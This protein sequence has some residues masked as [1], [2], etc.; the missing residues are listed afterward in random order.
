MTGQRPPLGTKKSRRCLRGS[1][2]GS[3]QYARSLYTCCCGRLASRKK[4]FTAARS[5]NSAQP[6]C[7]RTAK[8]TKK[9][10][11]C[12][13]MYKRTSDL[14]RRLLGKGNFSLFKYLEQSFYHWPACSGNWI[15][16]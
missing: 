12:F 5:A 1:A 6:P 8:R 7:G 10:L 9:T 2:R 13:P 15:C 4:N 14:K 11:A 16:L 3:L